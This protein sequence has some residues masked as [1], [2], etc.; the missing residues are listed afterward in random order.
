MLCLFVH[1][2]NHA[3]MHRS[4]HVRSVT[5]IRAASDFTGLPPHEMPVRLESGLYVVITRH[6]KNLN[7]ADPLP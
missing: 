7:S 1:L 4:L 5:T 6:C 2:V 3:K